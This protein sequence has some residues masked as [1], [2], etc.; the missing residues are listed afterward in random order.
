MDSHSNDSNAGIRRRTTPGAALLNA[1]GLAPLADVIA[2]IRGEEALGRAMLAMLIGWIGYALLVALTARSLQ[3][4]SVP[5]VGVRLDVFLAL[6]G[7]IAVF[8]IA[9]RLFA[10]CEAVR[11]VAAPR[12]NGTGGRADR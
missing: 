12:R 6:Q 8:F 10:R 3:R 11:A 9:L 2:R 1:L 7:M 5:I 4:L